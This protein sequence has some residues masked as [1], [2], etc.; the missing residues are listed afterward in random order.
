[1]DT[2][3]DGKMMMGN[4]GQTMNRF[5]ILFYF[6]FIFFN[7]STEDLLLIERSTEFQRCGS[8]YRRVLIENDVL[9]YG[10]CRLFC[11][12]VWCFR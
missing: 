9:V 7:W 5:F 4:D 3:E 10:I 1:M 6:Y 11:D 2:G 12:L 8:L